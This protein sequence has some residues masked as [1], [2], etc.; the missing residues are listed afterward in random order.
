MQKNIWENL[1]DSWKNSQ[2]TREKPTGNILIEKNWMLFPEDQEKGKIVYS[3][4]FYSTIY[5]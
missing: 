2:Q 3:C 4:H 5:C 1:T